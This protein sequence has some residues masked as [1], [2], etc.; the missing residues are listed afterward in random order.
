MSK[1]LGPSEANRSWQP[2]IFLY[3]LTLRHKQA[4]DFCF[5]TNTNIRPSKQQQHSIHQWDAENLMQVE[6]NCPRDANLGTESLQRSQLQR[7]RTNQQLIPPLCPLKFPPSL[8]P[9]LLSPLLYEPQWI[10]AISVLG[11]SYKYLW[12]DLTTTLSFYRAITILFQCITTSLYT[13]LPFPVVHLYSIHITLHPFPLFLPLQ[14]ASPHS[15]FPQHLPKPRSPNHELSN[16]E[17]RPLPRTPSLPRP[18]LRLTHS[19]SP[20]FHHGHPP[21]SNP[22]CSLDAAGIDVCGLRILPPTSSFV[23]REI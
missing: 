2:Q 17:R 16:P 19:G 7:L 4:A 22:R 5:P 1:F 9:S 11:F 12:P 23:E 14:S 10:H 21:R 18:K 15:P 3:S 8:P 6:N 20:A 13:S